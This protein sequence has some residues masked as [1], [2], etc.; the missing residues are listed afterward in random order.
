M[1][2]E[3]RTIA[4]ADGKLLV[5]AYPCATRFSGEPP[6]EQRL[7]LPAAAPGAVRIVVAH[8]TLQGGPV[9]EGESDA[10]PF[11][12]ADLLALR[13]DYVALGHFHSVYPAWGDGETCQ[14]CFCY[15]GAHETVEF[16]S[17][18]GHAVLASV[19][20][21]QPT[22]LQRVKI[23][24]RQWRQLQLA[25]P[26][27]LDKVERLHQEAKAGDPGRYVIRLKLQRG[28]PWSVAEAERL[29]ELEAAL[30]AVGAQVERRGSIQARVDVQALDLAGLPTGA[31]KEALL[32][33]Q[34]DLEDAKDDERREVIESALQV[35]W[36]KLREAME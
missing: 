28:N 18:V 26:A 2:R 3:A 29:A 7:P 16:G 30:L 13:A 15:C 14:R 24:R 17:D 5:E 31:V 36:D 34:R 21:G 27:D 25:G 4:L 12:E 1:A 19:V 22:R 11:S 9:P 32:S 35:G 6:W 10:Y 20:A 23:G 8:G 33:L